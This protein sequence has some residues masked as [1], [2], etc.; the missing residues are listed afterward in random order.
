[1]AFLSSSTTISQS[2]FERRFHPHVFSSHSFIHSF[3]VLCFKQQI[4]P[5]RFSSFIKYIQTI[6]FESQDKTRQDHLQVRKAKNKKKSNEC[7][8]IHNI[9]DTAIFFSFYMCVC[10]CAY[11]IL[12]YSS[13]PFETYGV[14]LSSCSS[15]NQPNL[16]TNS[17][18]FFLSIIQ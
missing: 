5:N 16:Y 13:Q 7:F 10:A 9:L 18:S 2:S 4:R 14:V 12:L 17:F 8:G 11:R 15:N 1:M 3:M 6:S